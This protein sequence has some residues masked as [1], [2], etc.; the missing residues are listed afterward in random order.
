MSRTNLQAPCLCRTGETKAWV[1]V[2]LTARAFLVCNE[3][4]Y[5]DKVAAAY[6]L[7]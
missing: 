7:K 4:V 1:E 6:G 3:S 2:I 5:M